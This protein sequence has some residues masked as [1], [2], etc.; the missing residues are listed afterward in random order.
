M[1][2]RRFRVFGFV[3]LRKLGIHVFGVSEASDSERNNQGFDLEG[4]GLDIGNRK[5]DYRTLRDIALVVRIQS[6][7]RHEDDD[8]RHVDHGGGIDAYDDIACDVE[9]MDGSRMKKPLPGL[10]SLLYPS[11]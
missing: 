6:V 11:P 5:R 10:S 7:P 1:D 2:G 8:T 3:F 4:V 9:G